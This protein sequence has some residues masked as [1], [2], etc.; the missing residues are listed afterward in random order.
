M[1]LIALVESVEH[2]C[3]RYRLA[4]FR[5]LLERAG[6]ALA[7]ERWPDRWWERLL[8]GRIL[9]QRDAVVVQRKLLTGWQLGLVRR[10]ARRLLFDFDD[11]LFLRDSYA[12]RGLHSPRRL[13]RFAAMV[14]ASDAVLAGNSY[15][16]GQ[17]K[18]WT[19]P[20]RVH[21]VPTCVDPSLY[22]LAKHLRANQDV[23]LVWI[24]SSSTLQGL[25]ATRPL[26]EN[27]GRRLPGL[28]LKMICDRFIEFQHLPVIA[29]P[30]AEESETAEIAA[31]DIGISWVPDDAWSRGKCGLKVLQYMAAGLPVV[32]NPVGVQEE[33][34]KHGENGFLAGTADEWTE[35]IRRLTADPELR[36]R[37]GAAGRRR[38]E[39]DYSLQVGGARW[40][41]VLA[42]LALSTA[43]R[44]GA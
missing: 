34:V 13:R 44:A 42:Q 24:G 18:R 28:R 39:Q 40:I 8:V 26:L 6:H 20:E 41:E 10:S 4:A 30:W 27:L 11:A 3:A 7:L 12:A 33:M 25:E 17:A 35:A 43:M 16:A 37:M 14:R 32:A 15:L 36:R 5:P 31:A 21:L 29:C 22:P 23:Q 1:Q 19:A 9:R 38:V 2:V